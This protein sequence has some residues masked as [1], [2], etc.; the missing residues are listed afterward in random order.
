MNA[1]APT[2]MPWTAPVT[3][4]MADQ[5]RATAAAIPTLRTARLVL[6]APE[7]ADFGA[8]RAIACTD[9]GRYLDGP[10]SEPDA[11]DD[12][13]RMVATW[14]LRGHGVWAATDAAGQ[15]IGFVLIGFEPGDRE[16]ELGFLFLQG[17]EGQGLAQEAA[18][19]VR[20]HAFATLELTTLVSYIDPDN[21]RAQGLARRLG[22][23]RDDAAGHGHVWRYR[24]GG[25]R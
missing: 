25:A 23:V 20:D 10:M 17:H 14:V 7:L 12:F 22:A 16:P 3:A 1:A 6:R 13:C 18:A 8:Y 19:A 4:G 11:W 2:P 21:T 5:A 24:K 9:R 15:T